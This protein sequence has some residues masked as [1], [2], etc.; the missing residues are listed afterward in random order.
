MAKGREKRTRACA[1]GR[2]PIVRQ[3]WL[4]DQERR[5]PLIMVEVEYHALRLTFGVAVMRR[6][7]IELRPP[8]SPDRMTDG[9]R[10]PPSMQKRLA[11]A[12]FAAVKASPEVRHQR[13]WGA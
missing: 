5:T 2:D 12:V 3:V 6:G 4:P 9:V 11:E 7:K 13:R 1:G 8:L 10:M